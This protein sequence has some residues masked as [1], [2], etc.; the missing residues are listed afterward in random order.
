MNID[1][2]EASELYF[3]YSSNHATYGA[4]PSLVEGN[5]IVSNLVAWVL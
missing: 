2:S 1:T 5:L 3:L 4:P